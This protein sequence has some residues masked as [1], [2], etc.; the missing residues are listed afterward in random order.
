MINIHIPTSLVGWKTPRTLRSELE[1]LK[2]FLKATERG[3]RNQSC[4]LGT[5]GTPRSA[6]EGRNMRREEGFH[7]KLGIFYDILEETKVEHRVSCFY[8]L[9]F[10]WV[11]V[12]V[13]LFTEK[14]S[15]LV[16]ICGSWFLPNSSM[17][18]VVCVIPMFICEK[19]TSHS[20]LK[21]SCM[22]Q[23]FLRQAFSRRFIT[24]KWLVSEKTV[25][26]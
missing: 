21:H 12:Y 1:F 7:H 4:G 19:N 6:D 5:A 26:P 25:T 15:W 9:W 14:G 18:I 11:F 10:L 13:F 22:G 20:Q 3:S 8:F 17:R 2:E 24:M 23:P 16:L